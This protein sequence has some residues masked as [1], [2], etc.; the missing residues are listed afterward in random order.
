MLMPT[1]VCFLSNQNGA[2]LRI[3]ERLRAALRLVVAMAIPMPVSNTEGNAGVVTKSRQ[4][5]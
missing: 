2:S 1:T 3:I 5:I 4:R